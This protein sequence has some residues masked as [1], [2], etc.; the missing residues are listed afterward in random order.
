ML[1]SFGGQVNAV[2]PDATANVQRR[3]AFKLCLQTFWPDESDDD[4]FLAWERETF[5]GMFAATGG[6]PVPN[7]QLDGCYINYPDVDMAD[8]ARNRSGTG[9]QELYFKANYPR[10]QRA[11]QSW[12][13]TNF[14]THS[15]GIEL[16]GA[17]R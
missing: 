11:K 2:A 10:L 13:P 8:P 14:F 1:F 9:W 6:V 5:E 15:L 3:S 7:E 4:F 12:D 17:R 16:P